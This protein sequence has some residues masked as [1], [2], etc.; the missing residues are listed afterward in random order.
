MVASGHSNGRDLGPET[1]VHLDVA[2]AFSRQRS[3]STPHDYVSALAQHVLTQ[4]CAKV[5]PET[6][7]GFFFD[8]LNNGGSAYYGLGA[9]VEEARRWGVVMLGPCVNRSTDRYTVENDA[10]EGL[11]PEGKA[12]QSV[13]AIR[14][15]LNAIRGIGAEAARHIIAMRTAFGPFS[16]LLDF[17]SA[18]SAAC[19]IAAA[20]WHSSSWAHLTSP[21]CRALNWPW[22]SRCTQRPPTSYSHLTAIRR[23]SR[24]SKKG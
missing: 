23:R 3:P 6:A 15:P 2:S 24:R 1:F 21:R 18:L 19:S 22:P 20:C 11:T 7:A 4:A 17:S 12:Q 13:G 14:V 16:S 10:L 8:V 5:N 9:A